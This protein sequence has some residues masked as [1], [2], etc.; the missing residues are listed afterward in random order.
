ME[1]DVPKLSRL[2]E[3]FRM[4]DQEEQKHQS[5]GTAVTPKQVE[6]QTVQHQ[7]TRCC[8]RNVDGKQCPCDRVG[9]LKCCS[10]HQCTYLVDNKERCTNCCDYRYQTYCILHGP[11][12]RCEYTDSRNVRCYNTVYF[13]YHKNGY[14]YCQMHQCKYGGCCSFI[15]SESSEL[16]LCRFHYQH[17]I[18]CHYI[19]D[20]GQQ[21]RHILDNL[22]LKSFTSSFPVSLILSSELSNS[23]D[24]SYNSG[25]TVT[26]E[27]DQSQTDPKPLILA[28]PNFCSEHLCRVPNCSNPIRSDKCQW[29]L[30]H[31]SQ[32]H[33]I[34]QNGQTCPNY[35][36]FTHQYCQ[37]HRC[38]WINGLIDQNYP[39]Y[40]PIVEKPDCQKYC[41]Y[42][43][44]LHVFIKREYLQTQT[45]TQT[46]T[47]AQRQAQVQTC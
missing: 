8:F 1:Q 46:Q 3:I 28:N 31:S 15:D 30:N 18:F 2:I 9:V 43:Y 10:R 45:E 29:C 25:S 13:Q 33:F 44:E 20:N 34:L 17:T 16:Q 6:H 42:H 39:C 36:Y 32:C 41:A 35:T 37:S 22:S 23:D 21:C 4:S 12:C 5:S 11:R 7:D 47:Q 19:R 27:S 14:V 40:H 24:L 26:A 38:Q